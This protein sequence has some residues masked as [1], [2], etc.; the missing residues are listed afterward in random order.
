MTWRHVLDALIF[1]GGMVAAFGVAI[2]MENRSQRYSREF[3]RRYRNWDHRAAYEFDRHCEQA[4][5]HDSRSL[6]PGRWAA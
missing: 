3:D 4:G 1:I 2:W 5:V 6:L